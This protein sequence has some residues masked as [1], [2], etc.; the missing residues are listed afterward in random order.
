MNSTQL[1]LDNITDVIN[2]TTFNSEE[3][4]SGDFVTNFTL[5]VLDNI[6]DFINTTTVK[7]AH[8]FDGVIKAFLWI[9][10]SIILF[11]CIAAAGFG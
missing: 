3:E 5:V 8:N 11:M 9:F 7:S 6:T 2:A 1:V 10:C 4:S